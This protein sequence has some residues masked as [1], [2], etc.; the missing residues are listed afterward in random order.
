MSE[1]IRAEATLEVS[2]SDLARRVL[3]FSPS[4]PAALGDKVDAMLA[5]VETRLAPFSHDGTMTE[6]VLAIAQVARRM[7]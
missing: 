4:S 7:S 2:I 1:T 3:T 5:D 6:V